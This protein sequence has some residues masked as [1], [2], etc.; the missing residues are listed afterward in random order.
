MQTGSKRSYQGGLTF[1]PSMTVMLARQARS[2]P[3]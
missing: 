1:F 3:I 2:G